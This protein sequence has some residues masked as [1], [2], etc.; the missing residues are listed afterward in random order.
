MG[1]GFLL[2][3]NFLG[4]LGT[5]WFRTQQRRSEIALHKAHGATDRAIFSRLLSEGILLLAIVTPVALLIDYNL[6]HL[7]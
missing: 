6:A 5:F 4:L 2:L 1:I 7:E 3:N